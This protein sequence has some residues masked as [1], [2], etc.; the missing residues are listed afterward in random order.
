[1]QDDQKAKFQPS[2]ASALVVLACMLAHVGVILWM[3]SHGRAGSFV[4]LIGAPLL[5][6]IGCALRARE[7]SA[8][9]EWNALALS[10][11]LWAGGMMASMYQEVFLTNLDATPAL[12]MLLY[13]LYG[14]PVAYAL[15]G[16]DHEIRA[17][18]AIDAVLALALGV[19][20]VAHTFSSATWSGADSTGFARL[21]LMF[22]IE[23]VFLLLFAL[24][25]WYTAE[26]D[27]RRWFFRALS[28]YALLYA[29]VAGYVNHVDDSQYG[30]LPD[31][32]ISLPFLLMWALAMQPRPPFR[33]P[34]SNGP[35]IRFLRAAS[36][37]VLPIALLIVSAMLVRLSLGLAIAGFAV[38]TIGYGVRGILLQLRAAQ[39]RDRLDALARIDG[40][41]GLANRR[42]FDDALRMEWNR[43]RRSGTGL[44]LL[45]LDIDHFKQLND[46][47]GHQAGDAVLREV[48]RAL[49]GCV[50]RGGEVVARYGGEEFA[51]I[52]PGASAADGERVAERMRLAVRALAMPSS[53]PAGCV[54]ISIGVG[55]IE[56][57][58]SEDPG[59]LL[60]D[61]D[62][63]LYMAKRS[64]RDRV[65]R[66]V[67]GSIGAATR[68]KPPPPLAPA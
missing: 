43:A 41:T 46:E 25:R 29:G 62:N 35:V 30:A 14:V 3:P 27:A 9:A 31:L 53:V 37:L 50:H 34:R 67:P 32:A 63:A 7:G 38:A 11:L 60:R 54:T 52:L 23:N 56:V 39:E 22:D 58:T 12:G 45:L 28:L 48:A 40:L 49:S 64:G 19:L 20:F 68:D 13:V 36:T 10:M 42:Q 21:R 16:Y 18:R 1:M 61:A 47:Q 33:H 17:V 4:F 5:A 66:H 44:A 24:L 26:T 15:A 59:I 8:R 2:N 55:E 6:S 57:A 51:A 65:V